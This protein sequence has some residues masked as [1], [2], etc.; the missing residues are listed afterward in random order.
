MNLTLIFKNGKVHYAVCI[1]TIRVSVCGVKQVAPEGNFMVNSGISVIVTEHWHYVGVRF[2]LEKASELPS[3]VSG[4]MVLGENRRR[5]A[6]NF[7][8]LL[9]DVAASGY[10]PAGNESRIGKNKPQTHCAVYEAVGDCI[11]P[12]KG[13]FACPGRLVGGYPPGDAVGDSKSPAAGEMAHQVAGYHHLAGYG[14]KS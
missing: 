9:R 3:A 8:A 5:F 12:S 10:R 6:F 1:S 4:G 11:M 2:G 13:M 7:R 14:S